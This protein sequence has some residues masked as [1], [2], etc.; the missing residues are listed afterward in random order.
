[1]LRTP[2]A[3][4]MVLFCADLASAQITGPIPNTAQD[5]RTYWSMWPGVGSS[6]T[7]ED[8]GRDAEIEVKYRETLRTKIPD[9]KPSS[10]PW[11]TVRQAPAAQPD[12]HRVQ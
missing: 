8:A 2:L 5:D 4:L 7:P 12:R 10:D 11:R 6:R 9:R 3:A 1:M